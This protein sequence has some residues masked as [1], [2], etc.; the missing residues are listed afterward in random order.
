M[1][2]PTRRRTLIAI[3]ACI[4][5]IFV[6]AFAGT[7]SYIGSYS[8]SM[9]EEGH[10]YPTED[11]ALHAWLKWYIAKYSSVVCDEDARPTGSWSTYSSTEG[12][13]NYGTRNY[14]T[15]WG[16]KAGA[17]CYWN[18]WGNS[19][20]VTMNR[21]RT[22]CSSTQR[23]LDGK[24]IGITQ[25]N[26]PGMKGSNQGAT[27]SANGTQSC[28]EPINTA[29]GNMWH[30][31][32]D[33]TDRSDG[34]LSI[35][36]T[37]N[38]LIF[39]ST[40]A[41]LFGGRWTVAYDA[42]LN[43]VASTANFISQKCYQR[44]DNNQVFC[45]SP[46]VS[47][48][49]ASASAIEVFRGDGKYFVFNLSG[50]VYKGDKDTNDELVA[51]KS[52][53]GSVVG[54]DYKDA[55]AKTLEN[56]DANGRLLAITTRAGVV[57]RLT[58][59]D[60]STNDTH[61][62]RYPADA[63]A[64]NTTQDGEVM[65]SGRLVC[66]T[67][68]WGRQDLFKYD[69]AGRVIEFVDPAGHSYLYEY[70]GPTGGCI[71]TNAA[72]AA[73]TANNLTKVTYPDGAVK[74][75]VYNEINNIN[76]GGACG[77]PSIGNGFGPFVSIMTG[78]I[79]ELNV[80]YI[81]WFYNCQGL[82]KVSTH[83]GNVDRID[84]TYNQSSY[85]VNLYNQIISTTGPAST[86]VQV[87]STFT[88]ALVLN[89]YKNSSIDVPCTVC[90]PIR[91]RT[92]DAN[93]NVATTTDFNGNVTKYTYDLTRNLETSRVEASGTA[94]ARTTT[95]VW[96]PTLRLP[97]TIAQPKLITNFAYD[98]NGNVLSRT[99]QATSDVSGSSGT[100]AALVGSPRNWTYTYN[101]YGQV[102]S[103]VG[104]RTDIVDKTTYDYDAKG[105][106]AVV[107]N[108]LGQATTYSNYDDNGNVGRIVEP[109]G[110]VTEFTYTPRGK[111]GSR[112]V[113]VGETQEKTSFEYDPAGQLIRQTNPD[114]SWTSFGYDA[115]HRLTSVNDNLGNNITYTLDLTGNRIGEQVKDPAGVLTRQVARVFN[116][117]GQMTKVTGASR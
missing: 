69:P 72:S 73:C 80:R 20:Y 44:S 75:Y 3:F 60:G 102:T 15:N 112:T 48:P 92:F 81:S 111:V 64:C 71:P 74:Q 83:P 108:A 65:P 89:V 91:A 14:Q 113:S 85:G 36:R 16:V 63:P 88:P 82:A 34:K 17:S 78:L 56:Y 41:N 47:D 27:C 7:P 117:F 33:F 93:G 67:D 70:D 51:R 100:A 2:K 99:E 22:V 96:H 4:Y 26:I 40:R 109:S 105:N 52:A 86:P 6:P 23:F 1:Y 97:V 32:N 115:A 90:G 53:D 95:T 110:L 84:I 42:K 46:A 57:Y 19:S 24:C 68:V 30:L 77:I 37:Y 10:L 104:P 76:S 98:A 79:D 59:T 43:P 8:Y 101:A 49:L 45:E 13:E 106:L 94:N 28:G 87:T 31:E 11:E 50:D 58:Y 107:T 38:S 66:V 39:G 54:F 116:T 55:Q 21:W 5:F 103:M 9:G 62:G 25:I 12:V 29:T 18:G 114:G 61:V 35:K